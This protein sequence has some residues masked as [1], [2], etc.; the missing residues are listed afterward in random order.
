MS[1]SYVRATT[2]DNWDTLDFPAKY[3]LEKQR[4]ADDELNRLAVAQQ[5]EDDRLDREAQALEDEHS[6]QA[7]SVLEEEQRAAKKL[8]D[9]QLALDQYNVRLQAHAASPT[10][11]R[12]APKARK[13]LEWLDDVEDDV[14]CVVKPFPEATWSISPDVVNAAF[15][16]EPM[17]WVPLLLCTHQ[18]MIDWTNGRDK[19]VLT[20][21]KG[22]GAQL[23]EVNA[24]AQK[25][26]DLYAKRDYCL[27]WPDLWAALGSWVEL[28]CAPQL[29]EGARELFCHNFLM[30]KDNVTR[31]YTE[32]HGP[33]L[34]EIEAKFNYEVDECFRYSEHIDAPL[35]V[36]LR[37]PI[38]EVKKL[39]KALADEGTC[40]SRWLG[41]RIVAL[42]PQRQLL[43]HR[44]PPQ[45]HL[46]PAP[47]YSAPSNQNQQLLHLNSHHFGGF[48]APPPFHPT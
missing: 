31:A 43:P 36:L 23:C 32:R 7:A 16:A 48:N 4:S 13:L 12:V 42:L 29:A 44:A 38:A 9:D 25:L 46:V 6:R 33:F 20:A 17:V 45:Q 28:M 10:K 37:T 11:A 41:D 26:L 2:P 8:L 18:A 21:G 3:E 24:T 15:M 30:L 14:V 1:T 47:Q 35:V 5:H 22:V 39:R 34:M 27:S 40:D 19:L